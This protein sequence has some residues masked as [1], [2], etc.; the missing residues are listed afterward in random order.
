MDYVN[1]IINYQDSTIFRAIEG[2][3]TIHIISIRFICIF[4]RE[5]FSFFLDK[6]SICFVM[7]YGHYP[8]ISW[9]DYCVLFLTFL[10]GD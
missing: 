7:S 9:W 8:F 6:N 4:E 1:F 2:V 3:I 10:D 5:F